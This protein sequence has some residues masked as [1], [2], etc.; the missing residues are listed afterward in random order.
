MEW[1]VYDKNTFVS[2]NHFILLD[3]IEIWHLSELTVMFMTTRQ[4]F[5]DVWAVG[6]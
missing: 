1:S 2:G 6:Q 5:S 4:L 3:V